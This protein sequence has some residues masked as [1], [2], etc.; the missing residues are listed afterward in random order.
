MLRSQSRGKDIPPRG[1]SVGRKAV[2]VWKNDAN[3][4]LGVGSSGAHFD[5]DIDPADAA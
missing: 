5:C 3:G 2:V 1:F 4:V